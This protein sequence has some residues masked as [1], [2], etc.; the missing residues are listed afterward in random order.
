MQC[1]AKFETKPGKQHLCYNCFF[2]V[3]MEF[4]FVCSVGEAAFMGQVVKSGFVLPIHHHIY[5]AP[6]LFTTPNKPSFQFLPFF[7][8]RE[9]TVSCHLHTGNH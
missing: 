6:F 5:N 3:V 1:K 7:D 2:P 8:I 9:S 4:S